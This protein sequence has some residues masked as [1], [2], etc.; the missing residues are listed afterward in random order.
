MNEN[1]LSKR[2]KLKEW[3]DILN[4][5]E[6]PPKKDTIR[7][8]YNKAKGKQLELNKKYIPRAAMEINNKEKS[9]LYKKKYTELEN[10][11]S[12]KEKIFTNKLKLL[13]HWDK[14]DKNNM[15]CTYMKVAVIQDKVKE[16]IL[17]NE[18]T[19]KNGKNVYIKGGEY[20]DDFNKLLEIVDLYVKEYI[21]NLELRNIKKSP[22]I[23]DDE[24]KLNDAIDMVNQIL[25]IEN[26]DAVMLQSIKIKDKK[27]L[28][29]NL[30][31][32]I[33][34]LSLEFRKETLYTLSEF[35]NEITNI[36]DKYYP[37]FKG[38]INTEIALYKN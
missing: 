32:Q 21:E 14:L 16:F 26:K 18:Y 20:G 31:R 25:Y 6:N 34:I 5:L 2:L 27:D 10:K 28:K 38:L 33:Q 23:Y 22:T 3:I 1:Y 17:D 4:K 37:K 35:I 36:I 12:V 9:Y 15:E 29:K 24:K 7:K 30:T 19:N 13:F 11:K 8:W